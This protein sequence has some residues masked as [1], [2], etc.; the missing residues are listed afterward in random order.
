MERYKADDLLGRW[1]EAVGRSKNWTPRRR[2]SGIGQ[3]SAVNDLVCGFPDTA[4]Y[5]EIRIQVQKKK[6]RE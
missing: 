2:A 1:R 3:T 5:R 4:N 6:R